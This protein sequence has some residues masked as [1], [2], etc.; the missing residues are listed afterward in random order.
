MSDHVASKKRTSNA[1][2]R[3]LQQRIADLNGSSSHGPDHTAAAGSMDCTRDVDTSSKCWDGN[4]CPAVSKSGFPVGPG[5]S[6]TITTDEQ[7][8]I[9]PADN[10]GSELRGP[11]G[12]SQSP[13]LQR[14]SAGPMRDATPI[15]VVTITNPLSVGPPDSGFISHPSYPYGPVYLGTSS[16]WSFSRR[17]LNIT[18]KAVHNTSLPP[19]SFVMDGTAYDM[20]WDGSRIADT[21]FTPPLPSLS[22]SMYLIRSVQFHV[23]HTYHLFDEETFQQNLHDF[24]ENPSEDTRRGGLWFVHYLLIMALGQAF[25]LRSGEGRKP[26]GAEFF[27]QAMKLLPDTSQLWKDTFTATELYCCAALY[28]QSTDYRAGAYLTIGTA[29]RMA[30]FRGMH[31]E[32]PTEVFGEA[33]IERARRIWWTIY[34]LDRE[35]SSLMGLPVQISEENIHAKLP[36][37]QSATGLAALDIHIKLCRIIARVVNTVYGPDGR[38][39]QKFLTNTKSALTCL[40]AVADELNNTFKLPSNGSI[41]GISRQSATLHL[42]YHQCVILTT[43][44]LMYSLFSK[45]LNT[46]PATPTTIMT[47]RRLQVLLQMCIDSCQQSLNILASLFTQGLLESFLPFDLESAFCSGLM[48]FMGAFVEPTLVNNL[49]AAAQTTYR[50]I[51]DMIGK[52]NMVARFRKAELEQLSK[53]LEELEPEAGNYAARSRIV[54]RRASAG[55]NVHGQDGQTTAVNETPGAQLDDISLEG[56]VEPFGE[57]TWPDAMDPIQLMN[58]AESLDASRFDW[59]QQPFGG[60]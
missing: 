24:Y 8:R 29:L 44:P 31:T 26:P 3:S 22:H 33:Q 39:D 14:N 41:E 45:Q 48:I 40:A 43:R 6:N 56:N 9:A 55:P 7:T 36:S 42:V 35:L 60:L 15:D 16:N 30:L 38:L 21:V 37:L 47:M 59:F 27:V 4:G 53:M 18:Q 51:D 17:V 5:R 57:W 1:Y 28:L 12:S 19:E 32:L 52:G 11:S 2:L 20:G 10:A 58:V 34:I 49:A 25:V 54:S 23:G 13:E 50:V 46:R